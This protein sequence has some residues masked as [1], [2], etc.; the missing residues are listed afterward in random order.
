MLVIMTVIGVPLLGM[1]LFCLLVPLI[2][3][4]KRELKKSVNLS[5]GQSSYEYIMSF[6]RWL[7]SSIEVYSNY[8]KF[9]YP[10]FFIGMAAQ[11]VASDAGKEAI[12]LLLITFPTDIIILG[13]PYYIS[14]TLALLT[15]L[16]ARYSDAIYRLDLNIVYGRQF[17][18]LAELIADMKELKHEEK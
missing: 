1:Y 5:K 14:A 3:I 17:K 16:A 10:M 7:K 8:Y 4:A 9:F 11:I 2:V 15:L 13:Q 12:G 18:K 6:D